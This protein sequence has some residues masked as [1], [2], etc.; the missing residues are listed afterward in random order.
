[1]AHLRLH[2]HGETSR[3]RKAINLVPRPGG[4]KE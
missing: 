4:P 2:Q 1:V 3:A